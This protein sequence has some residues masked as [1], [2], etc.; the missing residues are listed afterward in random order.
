[1][2]INNEN[3]NLEKNEIISFF[4]EYKR[5]IFL[6]LFVILLITGTYYYYKISE[7]KKSN[8]ISEKY[9]KASLLLGSKNKEEPKA[10]LEEIIK[11]KNKF[12]S[13]LALNLIIEK[14]LEKDKSKIIKYFKD[15]EDL[16]I[17]TESRNL[18]MLKKA[19]YLIR[20]SEYSEGKEI[21]QNLID[22]DS[23]FKSIA[24]D[25]INF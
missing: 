14:E 18:L 24:K 7:E 10:I 5:Y 19:L 16:T 9:I 17:S 2:D 22:S 13:I 11:S 6:I 12:Y 1:M 4:R 23:S 20:N 15:L 3:K 21:L 8:L 25:L